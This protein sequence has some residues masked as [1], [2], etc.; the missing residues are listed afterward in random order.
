MMQSEGQQ[1]QQRISIRQRT[2]PYLATF[3]FGFFAM[4]D[5]PT[6]PP[7]EHGPP[8]PY[9]AGQVP[10]YPSGHE[11]QAPFGGQPAAQTFYVPPNPPAGYQ[12][13]RKC[14]AFSGELSEVTDGP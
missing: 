6:A 1:Q 8:P 12:P 2:T 11:A 10:S 9:A 14:I 4:S 5:K 3:T 7:G 13:P